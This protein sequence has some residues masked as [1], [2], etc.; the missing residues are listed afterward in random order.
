MQILL[1][2]GMVRP[3]SSDG[4]HRKGSLS[5]TVPRGQGHVVPC[6]ATQVSTRVSEPAGGEGKLGKRLYAGFC[7][8][9]QARKQA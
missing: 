2:S 6:R 9:E 8:K 1:Y 5:L 7:G 3:I 4:C